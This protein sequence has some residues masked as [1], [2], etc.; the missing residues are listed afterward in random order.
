MK[1]GRKKSN[2]EN[3]LK[4]LLF[5]S[6]CLFNCK[7]VVKYIRL[8]IP[9]FIAIQNSFIPTPV[10]SKEHLLHYRAKKVTFKRL[11]WHRKHSFNI[12]MSYGLSISLEIVKM[13]KKPNIVIYR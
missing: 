2:A 5:F 12:F 6:F 4:Y 3:H 9:I 8:Y 1:R 11:Y 13:E 7:N 10:L